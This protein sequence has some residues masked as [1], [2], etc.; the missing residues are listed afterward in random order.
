MHVIMKLS[1]QN[2]VFEGEI[3]ARRQYLKANN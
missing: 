2:N 1:R 3:G